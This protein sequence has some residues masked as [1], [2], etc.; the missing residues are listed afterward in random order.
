MTYYLHCKHSLLQPCPHVVELSPR[1][2]EKEGFLKLVIV[3]V[4]AVL[5]AHPVRM[6]KIKRHVFSFRL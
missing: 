3:I 4:K 6:E 2:I 1:R 5:C